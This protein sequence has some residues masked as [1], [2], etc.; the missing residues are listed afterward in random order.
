MIYFPHK[1]TKSFSVTNER[2]PFNG[3]LPATLFLFQLSVQYYS[4]AGMC[5]I[6]YSVLINFVYTTCFQLVIAKT[7]FTAKVCQSL[8]SLIESVAVFASCTHFFFSAF[9]KSLLHFFFR[10]YLNL[11]NYFL[12]ECNRTTKKISDKIGSK[13]LNNIAAH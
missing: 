12:H 6:S 9:Q 8:S 3:L 11:T 7:I 10:F 2:F 13:F 5:T 4:I 1:T